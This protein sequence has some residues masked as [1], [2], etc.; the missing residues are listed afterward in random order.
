MQTALDALRTGSAARVGRFVLGLELPICFEFASCWLSIA[1]GRK[2]RFSPNHRHKTDASLSLTKLIISGSK[3]LMQYKINALVF[4][5]NR[6]RFYAISSLTLSVVYSDFQI[7]CKSI[8]L[9]LRIQY[10]LIFCTW[11]RD[12]FVRCHCSGLQLKWAAN[13]ANDS[14]SLGGS[15]F[16]LTEVEI[17]R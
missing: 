10:A 4:W 9:V 14:I 16:H 13:P 15:L 8:S 17:I 3:I 7:S 2:P 11:C 12:L 1:N 5:S 6:L